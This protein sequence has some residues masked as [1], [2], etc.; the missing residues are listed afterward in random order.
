MQTALAP[1]GDARTFLIHFVGVGLEDDCHVVE[2]P[3]ISVEF[4]GLGLGA[5]AH[6]A[7]SEEQ[8]RS[9]LRP[10]RPEGWVGRLAFVHGTMDR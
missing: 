5:D 2:T 8:G 9:R 6:T 4:Q 1:C 10:Q 3:P 7:R